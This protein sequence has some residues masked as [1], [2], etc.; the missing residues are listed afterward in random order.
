MP[1][2]LSLTT[3]AIHDVDAGIVTHHNVFELHDSV[4]LTADDPMEE[5]PAQQPAP[6]HVLG[7][8]LDATMLL[9]CDPACTLSFPRMICMTT[10]LSFLRP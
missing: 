9:F 2:V 7:M 6:L 5:E 3:K 4:D 8:L 1:H 10:L